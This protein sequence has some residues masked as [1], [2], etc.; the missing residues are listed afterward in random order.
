MPAPLM[1]A[2]LDASSSRDTRHQ[3]GPSAS[4]GG[5]TP[6]VSGTAPVPPNIADTSTAA[7]APQVLRRE[8]GGHTSLDRAGYFPSCNGIRDGNRLPVWN[9]Y[10]Y[11]LT[12]EGA[13]EECR[14]ACR[15]QGRFLASLLTQEDLDRFMAF[16]PSAGGAEVH[17]SLYREA[18]VPE[19]RLHDVPFSSSELGQ[20]PLPFS[21]NGSTALYAAFDT[22]TKALTHFLRWTAGET[23]AGTGV[24][25]METQYPSSTYRH[26]ELTY[27]PGFKK[28]GKECTNRGQQLALYMSLAEYTQ[29]VAQAPPSVPYNAFAV[30]YTALQKR[31]E[32][33]LPAIQMQRTPLN[34]LTPP[35]DGSGS[36]YFPEKVTTTTPHSLK[37]KRGR[38]TT[39]GKGVCMPIPKIAE[40]G[41]QYTYSVHGFAAGNDPWFEARRL[42]LQL[43][44]LKTPSHV[45]AVFAQI[46][47]A[48]WTQEYYHVALHWSH[49][50]SLLVWEDDTPYNLTPLASDPMTTEQPADASDCYYLRQEGGRFLGFFG[51]SCDHNS[52]LAMRKV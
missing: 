20:L 42:A 44:V 10:Y 43:A 17:L 47:A 46:D 29:L 15:R 33:I 19:W 32:W 18:G 40:P 31:L 45:T 24:H 13:R 11:T 16:W 48:E 27:A 35:T 9:C 49:G 2:P 14:W 52:L 50:L 51:G 25:C 36:C 26:V 12:E 5:Q 6:V 3:R 28:A 34:H 4:T 39:V 41:M 30:R 22:T 38:C 8:V 21:L 23:L 1:P 7:M 37:F